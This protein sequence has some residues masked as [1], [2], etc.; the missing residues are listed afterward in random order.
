MNYLKTKWLA[1]F[2]G[3]TVLSL[4][5]NADETNNSVLILRLKPEPTLRINGPL[6]YGSRPGNN[7]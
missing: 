1:V 4:A 5:M 2:I 7:G 6:L 3:T